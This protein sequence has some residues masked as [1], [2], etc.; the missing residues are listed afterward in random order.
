[1][2]SINTVSSD[3]KNTSIIKKTKHFFS[4]RKSKQHDSL[5]LENNG[6]FIC[7]K[8]ESNKTLIITNQNNDNDN[9]SLK[10]NKPIIM[11]SEISLEEKS[12]LSKS[13]DK[14]FNN[15]DSVFKEKLEEWQLNQSQI[16]E[17]LNCLMWEINHFRKEQTESVQGM[18]NEISNIKEN[19]SNESQ[20]I[21]ELREKIEKIRKK[22]EYIVGE[23]KIKE[24]NLD[25]NVL[26][27]KSELDLMNVKINNLQSEF[28]DLNKNFNKNFDNVKINLEKLENENET[29]KRKINENIINQKSELQNL[30][31]KIENLL[32][33]FNEKKVKISSFSTIPINNE[34]IS[35]KKGE[36]SNID[37][38]LIELITENVQRKLEEQYKINE[39]FSIKEQNQNSVNSLNIKINKLNEKLEEFQIYQLSREVEWSQMKI[40]LD[41]SM[42]YINK[43]FS[44]S[45]KKRDAVFIEEWNKESIKI[46]QNQEII[47]N[48]I[49]ELQ[50][51]LNDIKVNINDTLNEQQDKINNISKTTELLHKKNE[52]QISSNERNI[53]NNDEI[54]SIELSNSEKLKQT[55]TSLS[56][57][58]K[59]LNM[60]T[61]IMTTNISLLWDDVRSVKNFINQY[62]LNERLKESESN[63]EFSEIYNQIDD[64]KNKINEQ[65]VY[66]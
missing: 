56:N 33:E 23:N 35:T 36:L 24:R 6:S 19:I 58:I 30:N 7:N 59:L 64:L 22:S 32:S 39:L 51:A 31:L 10:Q 38:N 3:K 52:N 44:Q 17:K 49:V 65:K 12:S 57:D 37:D 15:T 28:K 1:M 26:N 43:E 34:E 29:Q 2:S 9:L 63:R 66:Q 13:E 53:N 61:K 47:N 55:I 27:Q 14:S 11:N 60:E 21:S 8:E 16:N 25:E 18:K 54:T 5:N 46:K 41:D 48:A 42:N 45:N 20:K 40:K 4:K 62:D 50:T